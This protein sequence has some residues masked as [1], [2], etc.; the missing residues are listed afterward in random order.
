M[1][2]YKVMRALEKDAEEVMNLMAKNNWKVISVNV[3]ETELVE[4]II[5][6]E[7]LA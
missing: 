2:E 1:S 6:F 5:T 4:L 3:L 7:R